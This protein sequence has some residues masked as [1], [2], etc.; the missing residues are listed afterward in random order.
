MLLQCDEIVFIGYSFPDTDFCSKEL[1]I[2]TFSKNKDIE[3][4]FVNPDSNIVDQFRELVNFKK[5]V[6]LY[7]DSESYIK[8]L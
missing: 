7:N 6:K 3:V 1:F 5:E 2:E 4:T 8:G